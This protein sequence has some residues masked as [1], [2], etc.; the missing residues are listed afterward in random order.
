M[1]LNVAINSYD[2]A[3]LTLL[4]SNQFTEIKG[5]ELGGEVTLRLPYLTTD[6]RSISVAVFKKF[7]KENLFQILCAGESRISTIS[8]VESF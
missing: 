2:N 5:C 4:V 7:E 8:N 6:D 1:C 3:L